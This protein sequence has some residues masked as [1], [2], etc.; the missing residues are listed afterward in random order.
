MANV[1]VEES[2]MRAIGDAI[3]EKTGSST[4]ILPADMPIAIQ[5]I[6]SGSGD[7]QEGFEAGTEQGAQNWFD[8]FQNGTGTSVSN[9]FLYAFGGP[10]WRDKLYKPTRPMLNLVRTTGMYAYSGITDTKVPIGIVAGRTTNCGSTFQNAT[11][12][13]T[14]NEFIVH[15]TLGM[16]S[17]FSG[18][19]KLVNLK[20]TGTIGKALSVANCEALNKNSITN[21]IECLSDSTTNLTATFNTTAVN[22]AFETSEGAADGATSD[23]W[24]ALV[25]SKPN[26]SFVV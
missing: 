8:Q 21:L 17:Q 19:T 11:S 16:T 4:G 23:K 22:K 25:A 1:F 13:I 6:A 3:R 26:W 5:N 7:Y 2:T 18:C 15:D 14:I 12:L 20:I 24:L 10:R 9:D